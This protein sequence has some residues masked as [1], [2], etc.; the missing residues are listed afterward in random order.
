MK[1][2]RTSSRTYVDGSEKINGV[3]GTASPL[4]QAEKWLRERW[5]QPNTPTYTAVAVGLTLLVPVMRGLER[6]GRGGMAVSRSVKPVQAKLNKDRGLTSQDL[7]KVLGHGMG[8]RSVKLR[9]DAQ[10]SI[11]PAE[12]SL[13]SP[14]ARS[15][16]SPISR[17]RLIRSAAPEL[18]RDPCA[19]SE[20]AERLRLAE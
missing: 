9:G 19:D 2:P 4:Q 10:L 6:V 1:A 15:T 11:G 3:G 17:C 5:S 12:Y 7:M 16:S 20:K 8:G 13:S 14:R 18:F